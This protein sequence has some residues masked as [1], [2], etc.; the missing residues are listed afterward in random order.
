MKSTIYYFSA[1]GNSLEITRQI[2]KELDSCT[3]KSMTKPP[4][5]E[6]VGGPDDII[7]FVFPVYYLGMPSLVEQFVEKLNI[8]PGT[9]CFGVSNF[10][11]FKGNALGMLEKILQKK[12]NNLA[13]AEE[14][15]MPTNYIVSYPPLNPDK[16][17]EILKTSRIKV[18]NTA[19]NISKNAKKPVSMNILSRI[20]TGNLNRILYKNISNWD[21]KFVSNNKCTCCEQCAEICPVNN[22]KIENCHPVWQHH[23]ERCLRCI[24]WCPNEAIQYGKE[25]IA[26]GRYHHPN[27]TAE[28]FIEN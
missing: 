6:L 3:I 14:I 10:A 26:R 23:C 24:Q 4:T 18:A 21:E 17:E 5:K 2:S 1:T 22:I 19:K 25:T 20:L 7:G 11:R 12:G 8:L 28:N 16:L 15:K 9:Y 13:Y 27:V